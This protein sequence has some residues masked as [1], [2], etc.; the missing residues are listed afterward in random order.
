MTRSASP[1]RRPSRSTFTA[2]TTPR[3]SPSRPA[4]R[5]RSSARLLPD[6]AAGTFTDVDSG[7]TLTYA[8]TAADGSPLPTWLIFTPATRTFSGTP[9]AANVGTLG[10]RV[11][12]TDIGG[13]TA[14]ETFNIAVT[15]VQTPGVASLIGTSTQYQTIAANVTDVD[16]L[17]PGTLIDYQWQ[18]EKMVPRGAT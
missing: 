8:A 9:T 10:V 4:T 17:L 12:A 5:T 6:A 14:S 11:T 3:C 16:G 1:R 13:L 2:P 7:D 18:S 15:A